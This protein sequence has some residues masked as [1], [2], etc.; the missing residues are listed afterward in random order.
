M[1]R[2][3]GC[4]G[5][6]EA[7]SAGG[8]EGFG[9]LAGELVRTPAHGFGLLRVG[10]GAAAGVG[11]DQGGDEVGVTGGEAQC[12]DAAPGDA[13]D[14]GGAAVCAD[15]GGGG[16]GVAVEAGGAVRVGGV[17]VAGGVPG[18]DAY[19]VGEAVELGGEGGGGG[20]DAVEAQEQRGVRVAG[21]PC[22][23]P[24]DG[25]GGGDGGHRICP[26]RPTTAP[27]LR[28]TACGTT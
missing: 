20:A 22:M 3:R 2:V 21:F 15:E 10:A 25:G 8:G 16:V 5:G 28:S 1:R 19:L 14:V 6:D 23:D 26:A 7:W 9:P 17:R 27:R 11:D 4:A 24:G 13:E 18:H 12:D